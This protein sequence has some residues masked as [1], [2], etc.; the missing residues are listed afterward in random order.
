M[1]RISLPDCARQRRERLLSQRQR[2]EAIRALATGGEQGLEAWLE[3]EAQ[4]DPDIRERIAAQ[5][6]RLERQAKREKRRIEAE[7]REGK[8]EL[9][10]TWETERQRLAEQRE[11]LME[12]LEQTRSGGAST[13]KLAERSDV[14]RTAVG[15]QGRT[16]QPSLWDRVKQTL[17]RIWLWIAGL[18]SRFV[19]WLG[20]KAPE[21]PRRA[22]IELPDGQTLDLP[23]LL[24]GNPELRVEVRRRVSGEGF[25][26]RLKALWRRMIGR[27]DYV[28]M[29]EKLMREELESAR[30]AVEVEQETEVEELE[31]KV[32][33]LEKEQRKVNREHK[34]DLEELEARREERLAELEEQ[35]EMGPYRAV[36]ESVEAELATAGLVD[37]EG[38]PTQSALEHL[39][40]MVYEETRRALPHGGQ[41]RAGTFAGAQEA[42]E[43]QPMRSLNERGAMDLVST[44]VRARQNHPHVRHI[45]DDDVL[46][47]REIRADTTHVVL[48][49]D[50][51]GSMEEKG[52]F[53]AAKRACLVMYK[54]V[55]DHDPSNRIDV[56]TMSTDVERVDLAGAWNAE[57]GGFTNHPLAIQK[58]HRLLEAGGAD[59]KLVYLVTDGLPEAY[60]TPDG[61]LVDKPDVCLPHAT[62]A[63][64]DLSEQTGARLVVIQLETEDP[65]FLEAAAEIAEAAGGHVE[66]LRPEKLSE[67]VLL[68][69]E[70]AAG[71]R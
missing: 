36:A 56:L 34:D 8:A 15:S 6:E 45:Y 17:L 63:A 27:E 37:E 67:E 35:V 53:E 21:T 4:R 65:M 12:R 7:A 71:G 44:V 2:R 68:D 59:R 13:A 55:Q 16:E 46:V 38:R 1:S 26:E 32:Q 29:A 43:K 5:R 25:S 58:A 61:N 70:A 9:E 49:L 39:A 62:Q 54:A 20:G 28:E 33:S 40:N 51:S 31:T 22:T 18:W 48:I 47:H 69:F 42:Y 3:A 14:L 11:D 41:V 64:R 24:A 57:L 30:Q 50:R 19:R 66:A 10:G 23:S 60:P 52:R